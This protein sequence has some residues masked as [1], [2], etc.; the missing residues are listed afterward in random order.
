MMTLDSQ[1]GSSTPEGKLPNMDAKEGGS[2]RDVWEKKNETNR[3]SDEFDQVEIW[4]H[5][6]L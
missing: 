3:F 4:V 2:R 5:R 1:A 6:H